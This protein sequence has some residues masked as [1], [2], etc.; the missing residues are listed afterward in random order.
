M[1]PLTLAVGIQLVVGQRD[2]QILSSG[3][4]EARREVVMRI[5]AT[6]TGERSQAIWLALRREV[7]RLVTCLD[8]EPP[9]AEVRKELH[10]EIRPGSEDDY[11]PNLIEALSQS[12]DPAMI[13]TLIKVTPGGG[14]AAAALVHFG[15]LAVP[16]LI[17]SALSSR[18]GPWVTEAGGSMFALAEMLH[19]TAVGDRSR[20]A[21]TATARTLLQEKVID[22]HWISIVNLALS[23]R[24]ADLRSEVETLA[25]DPSEWIRRGLTDPARIAQ[26]QSSIRFQLTRHPKPQ[27]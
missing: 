20:T 24:D 10:C 19:G 7:D 8:V 11:L 1:L 14:T 5:L 17:E 4:I 6:P 15:D 12:P 21:I 26:R 13:P 2:A 27:H 16:A 9:T 22:A 18:S 3:G 23:T 25:A